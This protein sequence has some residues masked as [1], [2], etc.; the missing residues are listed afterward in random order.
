MKEIREKLSH[1]ITVGKQAILEKDLDFAI[2]S[3][4]EAVN[5]A[6]DVSPSLNSI[7]GVSYS[8]IALALGLKGFPEKAFEK[9]EKA[10]EYFPRKPTNPISYASVLLGL[11]IDFQKINLFKCSIIILKNSLRMAKQE[12]DEP[13]LEAISIITH[14]LALSYFKI[15]KKVS[16]A[17]LFRIAGDLTDKKKIAINLYRNSAYLYYQEEMKEYSV[18]ILETAFDKSRVVE[19]ESSQNEIAHFQGIISFEIFRNYVK[20]GDLE[21]AIAYLDLSNKKFTYS[22]NEDFKIRVLYEKAKI[23]ETMGKI[24]DRN[25]VLLELIRLNRNVET[26]EYFVKALLQLTISSLQEEH[27]SD[28]E[29]YIHQITDSNLE[30][31][32]PPLKLKI[33]ELRKI[34]KS[35]RKHELISSDLRFSRKDLDLPVEKLISDEIPSTKEIP[36]KMINLDDLQPPEILV[37]SSKS[38][39]TRTLKRPSI[40]VLQD[41]FD[42]SD[43]TISLSNNQVQLPSVFNNQR[44]PEQSRE[45]KTLNFTEEKSRESENKVMALS[46]LFKEHQTHQVQLSSSSSPQ[47]MNSEESREIQNT[48]TDTFDIQEDQSALEN[49]IQEAMVKDENVRTDVVIRLQKAGWTVNLNFMNISRRGSEPD[50]LAEKG[51]IRK[52]KKMI[53]FAEN[54]A[55][56]EIC[57]FLLQSNHESGEKIIFLINGSPREVIITSEVKIITRIDQLF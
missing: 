3:F 4:E 29:Y 5:I 44:L 45:T 37:S 8:Y 34:L 43:D 38:S 7:I 33:I 49:S 2:N 20:R 27:Y 19:D 48:V 9:I 57:S 41:L 1:R 40:E 18:N 25:E 16:A 31:I 47:V 50:I 30:T 46:R 35:S 28:A 17:K 52:N 32:N 10:S 23:F 24:K 42:S 26:E 39:I 21:Q 6:L 56:A 55:D 15:G 53:F 12:I 14:N 36:L 22:K 11:G 51:I 54:P 13:N